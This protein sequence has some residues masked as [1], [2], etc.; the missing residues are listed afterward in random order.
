M[1]IDG[2]PWLSPP[3]IGCDEYRAGAVTGAL[4]V[5]I[6]ASW[7]NVAVGFAVDLTAL[8]QR[9]GGGQRVGLWGRDG[10]EQPALRQPCLE[11]G[12]GLPGGVAGL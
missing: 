3:S 4:T 7:T 12:G 2:E 5:A 6:G 11:R 9:A 10:L 1:D 8:D